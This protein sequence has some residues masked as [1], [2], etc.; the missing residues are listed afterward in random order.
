MNIIALIDIEYP[1]SIGSFAT[2][3]RFRRLRD[4]RV[5]A[6]L[7]VV[8]AS[9]AVRRSAQPVPAAGS[10]AGVHQEGRVDGCPV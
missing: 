4:S 10:G 7:S 2:A 8:T 6:K 9:V 5:Y 1:T 3:I